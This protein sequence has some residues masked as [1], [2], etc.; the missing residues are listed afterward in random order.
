MSSAR[1]AVGTATAEHDELLFAVRRSV[2]YHRHRERFL[3]R[4]HQLGVVLAAF[5]GAATVAALLAELPA[6]WTWVGL[7]AASL[8]VLAGATELVFGPAR[9]ARRHG[10]LAVSLLALE[11]DLLRVG[12][13]LTPAALLKLQSRRLDIEASEPPVYRVLDGNGN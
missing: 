4:V 7:F 5:S 13:S 11:K 12:L 3:D 8:T 1:N 9:A 2:R 6:G 10:S